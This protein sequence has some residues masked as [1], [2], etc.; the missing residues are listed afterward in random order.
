MKSKEQPIKTSRRS[1]LQ[2]T[3]SVI[4]F[5]AIAGTT[6]VS[7]MASAAPATEKSETYHYVPVFFNNDEWRFILS[8]TD[9]LIPE[10]EFGPG[11]V[12]EGVPIYIDKQM[13]L[14]YG[15]GYLWYMS[16]P[17]QESIPEMGYQTNLVPRE[18]YRRGIINLNK[19]CRENFQKNFADLSKEKQ[20]AILHDLESGKI[21]LDTI[22]G[23]LFFSQL[24]QNTKEGYL[25]D[26]VHGGNQTMA[27]WKLIGFP[28]ARAD[29]IQV[30]ENPDKSYP[31]GP[32]SISGKYGAKK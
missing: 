9:L 18:I 16:P 6:A 21:V 20:E 4:P 3:L 22:S 5:T 31:L 2:K 28:G 25:A 13:E 14:P 17:F 12:S 1:F 23:K 24:L 27:S 11:A 7:A 30:M 29:F 8:A 19:Y 26:P 15:Y 32:V 10:D